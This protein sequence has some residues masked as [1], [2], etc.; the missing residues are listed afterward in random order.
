ME[1]QNISGSDMISNRIS[2]GT[3]ISNENLK[4]AEEPVKERTR[5]PEENKGKQIDTYA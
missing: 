2:A 1:V 3:E 4:P 5:I